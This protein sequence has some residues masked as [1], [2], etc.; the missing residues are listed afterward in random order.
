MSMMNRP[1]GAA[2]TGETVASVREYEA[3]QK[4]VSTLIAGEVP[5]RDIAIVGMG[6]RTIERVTGR[7]G[8]ATA[9][10]SGAMNGLLIG[11]FLSAIF[12]L[13]NPAAPIQAFVGVLF[14]GVAMGMLLSLVTYAIVRRRRD[15]AS[16]MQLAGDHYEVTVLP[17]SLSKAR[18]VL[19][20][21]P[22]PARPAA[23]A[24]V[25]SDAEPPR[26]GERVAPGAQVPGAQVPQAQ[27]P[28]QGAGTQRPG[29]ES[30]ADAASP[31]QEEP[32]R[33][34][35]RIAPPPPP[36]R[37]AAEAAAAGAPKPAADG[38]P[39]TAQGAGNVSPE[40]EPEPEPGRASAPKADP[41]PDAEPDAPGTASAP[42]T[43]GG[44]GSAAPEGESGGSASRP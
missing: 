4:L 22:A 7:L 37:S 1:T 26:Y 19:G 34:G 39:A 41:A 10:R 5:A 16:V 36:A 35:E 2:E 8:Y 31:G 12:V 38:V 6:V 30:V 40:P 20:R 21:T 18:Q 33:Y 29:T 32:P 15:Y 17:G 13:G 3:A 27:G 43:A 24:T 23:P 14:V 28:A 25:A 9:A 42:E 11:L 44:E